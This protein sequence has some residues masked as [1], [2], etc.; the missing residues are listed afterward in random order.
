MLVGLTFAASAAAHG[1]PGPVLPGFKATIKGFKPGIPGVTARVLGGEDR[2]WLANHSSKDLTIY[3]YE[4]E[5]YL[6][7]T[8]RGIFQNQR[9]PAA[10]LNL[11]RF[12]RVVVPAEAHAGARPIWKRIAKSRAWAWHDHRIHWMSTF[13]PKPVLDDLKSPHHIFDWSV[14]ARLGTK[15]VAILGSLDYEPPANP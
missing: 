13:P 10:Y 2:L 8:P 4:G 14:S 3:G 9:S 5:P 11:D 6:R 1:G 15:R 7:L 12:A